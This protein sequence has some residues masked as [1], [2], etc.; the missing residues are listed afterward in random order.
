[1]AY[2]LSALIA[3]T[4]PAML[5]VPTQDRSAGPRSSID[6]TVRAPL[7]RKDSTKA[8]K[9]ARRA[10]SDFEALHRRLLPQQ[11]GLAS[12]NCEVVIGRFCH[13]QNSGGYGP[14]PEDPDVIEARQKLLKTLDSLGRVLPGDRWILA[15]RLRY[16]IEAGYPDVA[17]SIATDCATNAPVKATRSWCRA[18]SGYT[19]QERGDY[20]NA[21]AAFTAALSEMPDDER[22]QWQDLS[23][24]LDGKAKGR[25][26]K[27]S[28]A[29]RDSMATSL[30]RM[31]QPLYLTGVND[32][33]TEF[34]ARVTRMYMEKDSRNPMSYSQGADD[35]ETLMRYGGGLWYTQDEPPPGSTRPSIV[36]SHRRGPAFNFFPD[37]KALA[38]PEQ[39]SLDDWD[40]QGIAARTR[41]A[42]EY[43][44][45]FHPLIN[46]QL[47]VFRRGDS[48]LIVAAFDVTADGALGAGKLNAGVFAAVLEN[49]LVSAPLGGPLA[50]PGPTAISTLSAPWRPLLVSLEVID[51]ASRAAGR[52][53]YSVHLPAAGTRL[54]LSD[55]LLYAPKDSTPTRLADAMPLALHTARVSRSQPLG[56]FWETYGVRP[57]GESF[58]VAVLVEPIGQ[59]WFKRAAQ[60]LRM[61][62]KGKPLSVNWQ[63]APDAKDGIASRAVAVDLS[64]LKPGRYR[65]R[66]SL[67]PGSELP[68]VAVRE[69]EVM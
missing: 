40:L 49:G 56:L 2:M 53:R 22:C 9:A 31:V 43:A 68:L 7:A 62:E 57:E 1:M 59:S 13:W 50:N 35:R 33:R 48:A 25:Y 24:I 55:L 8:L 29:G 23:I 20:A 39:L 65:V 16:R 21:E 46:H 30:W 32:L 63:E 17:D 11:P 67:T 60:K 52:A 5:H 3:A 51:E 41:Y 26:K 14:P 58:R 38:S 64:S 12:R 37:S 28:C 34:L 19:A 27:L 4:L 10:Q 61:A 18:M 36:A 54:S 69:I 66:L 6:A 47:A 45:F 15:Q 42:P 44:Q